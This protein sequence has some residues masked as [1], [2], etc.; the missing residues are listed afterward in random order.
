MKIRTK[1]TETIFK[2]GT[3]VDTCN[4]FLNILKLYASRLKFFII[5][6]I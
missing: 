6:S 3:N 1:G 2:E 5:L 4:I